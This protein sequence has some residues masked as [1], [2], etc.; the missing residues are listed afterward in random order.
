[1]LQKYQKFP[2]SISL[3]NFTFSFHVSLVPSHAP[4]PQSRKQPRRSI[5]DMLTQQRRPSL[6]PGSKFS[7]KHR[8]IHSSPSRTNGSK[9]KTKMTI[10]ARSKLKSSDK[11]ISTKWNTGRPA[12]RYNATFQCTTT[13]SSTLK[14]S[15][16]LERPSNRTPVTSPGS[17]SR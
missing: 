6:E 8:K 3:S 10:F 7:G 2:L 16:P 4:G 12:R 13:S 1:M 5:A 11:N 14:A 17:S 15:S 9:A